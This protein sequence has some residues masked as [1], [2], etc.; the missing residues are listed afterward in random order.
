VKRALSACLLAASAVVLAGCASEPEGRVQKLD[1]EGIDSF[2]QLICS[3]HF[4]SARQ[5][6]FDNYEDTTD[7]TGFPVS[8]QEV[9]SNF[10]G[11]PYTI[12]DSDA[13]AIANKAMS[14]CPDMVTGY[15]R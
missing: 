14:N 3:A 6:A 11:G 2:A 7:L 8:R 15:T 12:S 5:L 10:V 4:Q 9:L 1:A 13:D